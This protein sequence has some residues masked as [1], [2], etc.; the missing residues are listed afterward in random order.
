M[1]VKEL[2]PFSTHHEYEQAGYTAKQRLAHIL[3]ATLSDEAEKNKKL[4]TYQIR[5]FNGLRFVS[6]K[7]AVQIDHL[8]MHDCGFIVIENRSEHADIVVNML[9]EWTQRFKGKELRITSPVDQGQRKVQFLKTLLEENAPQLRQEVKRRQRFFGS[10]PFELLVA[11]P[12]EGQFD[13]PPRVSLREACPAD[14]IP[15]RVLELIEEHQKRSRGRFGLG[16]DTEQVFDEEE[17]FKISGFIRSAHSPLDRDRLRDTLTKKT[18][19][20]VDEVPD[21]EWDI[22]QVAAAEEDSASPFDTV[23]DEDVAA[24][25]ISYYQCQNCRSSQLLADHQQGYKMICL[26]CGAI[27][28]IDRTCQ[29]CGENGYV[30]RDG[31]EFY[32][33]CESCPSSELFFVNP[34]R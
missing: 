18:L 12:P 17:I 8:V 3:R 19:T 9:G 33:E 34:V 7:L 13:T 23:A 27:S 4:E 24:Y 1:V 14:E 21:D 20:E 11:I 30:R 22:P 16:R 29:V 2:D 10:V 5:I 15:Q 31:D 25:S 28:D 26:D 6:G 32:I